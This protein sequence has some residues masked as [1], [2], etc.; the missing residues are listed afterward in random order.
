MTR[1]YKRW[2]LTAL[3]ALAPVF[4]ACERVDDIS[5]IS[6]GPQFSAQ[7]P[8][9][10]PGQAKDKQK[11]N[12]T[13]VSGSPMTPGTVLAWIKPGQDATL[14]V[15]GF[16]LYVPKGSVARPTLITMTVPASQYRKVSLTAVDNKGDA[17]TRFPQGLSLTI[18]YDALAADVDPS[19][20]VI[21]YVTQ[22][23]DG[24]HNI[25]E[26]LDASADPVARTVTGTILHFSDYILGTL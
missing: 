19:K 13:L 17:V 4:T 2:L 10:A 5:S 21:V 23:A 14:A 7:G 22:N 18:P 9:N 20:L 3:L 16:R 26:I 15:G 1:T 6:E 12:V 8:T 11:R 25:L 24:S